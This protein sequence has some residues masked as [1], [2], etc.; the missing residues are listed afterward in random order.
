MNKE[1]ALCRGKIFLQLLGYN[2]SC[3]LTVSSNQNQN[4]ILSFFF[5]LLLW[6][7]I[8]DTHDANVP[9]LFDQVINKVKTKVRIFKIL[10]PS[11]FSRPIENYEKVRCIQWEVG[12]R[13]DL[14]VCVPGIPFKTQNFL[15]RT[16]IS[17][18]RELRHI[19][20]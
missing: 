4:V 12:G 17:L 10:F 8:S 11:S 1:S 3:R 9:N 20:R 14:I 6:V 18:C 19:I 2:K 16:K 5:Y 13:Y 15:T 7:K